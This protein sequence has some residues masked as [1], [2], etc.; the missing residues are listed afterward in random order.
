MQTT[1]PYIDA[2]SVTPHLVIRTWT[3]PQ[4]L[5]LI[6][7]LRRPHDLRLRVRLRQAHP[8]DN[9]RAECNADAAHPKEINLKKQKF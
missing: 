9:E 5:P 3:L 4:G 8:A 7:R 6:R 2:Q 1:V